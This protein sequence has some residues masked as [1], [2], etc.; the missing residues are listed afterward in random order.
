M[1]NNDFSQNTTPESDQCKNQAETTGA[2][3]GNGF[4]PIETPQ[5]YGVS[6]QNEQAAPARPPHPKK[7]PKKKRIALV[8]A[9]VAACILFSG[10]MLFGGMMLAKRAF[11]DVIDGKL[12]GQIASSSENGT[13]NT[14]S[15]V[16]GNSGAD[17]YDYSSVILYKND[18]SSGSVK[19][20]SAG[21]SPMSLIDA[22]ATVQDSVV[23]IVSTSTSFRGTVAAGAGSGVIINADGIIVTNN[24]VVSGYSEIYVIVTDH[25]KTDENGA[26]LQTKYQAYVR[27]TDEDGDIAI[28]KINPTSA[29]TVAKLGCSSNIALAEEVFAIG[30]PLGELGGTVTNGIISSI[31]RQVQIDGVTMTLL[32]TNAAINS[33]NSGGGLFNLAG[34]L[35]GI[36]N[37]KYSATG[38]EG[39]GF[40]IPIDSAIKSIDDILQ[41]GFVRGVPTL[42]VTPSD[43]SYRI[44]SG[45]YAR[46]E[47]I[48]YVLDAG[49]SKVL[50]TNDIIRSVDGVSV[51]SVSELNQAIRSHQV[52]DTVELKITRDNATITVSVTL[53]EYNPNGQ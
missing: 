23:E 29:L 24:H 33:G 7:N 50:K 9:I 4:P 14:Q 45:F 6:Y 15:D 31:S 10:L 17:S 41:Y 20:G 44:S 53:A 36:V 12:P 40:A 47:T 42:G 35:I 38:V 49:K 2:D 32:Q 46:Y 34:E 22:V 19:N 16:Y 48:V 27:G 51:S 11:S 30:N 26:Y 3:R 39:L 8:A 5:W 13:Q 37:A 18:G 43:G 25:S 21:D 28:L 1:N 52:G